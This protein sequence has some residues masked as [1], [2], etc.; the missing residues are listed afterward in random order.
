MND[1]TKTPEE[2]K[3]IQMVDVTTSLPKEVH[4]MADGLADIGVKAIEV[5]ADGWQAEDASP[6]IMKSVEKVPGMVDGI[7]MMD[8]E[9]EEVPYAFALA[10]AIAGRKVYAAI[11]ARKAAKIQG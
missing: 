10:W 7:D 3:P 9:A 2:K 11:K 8:D 1:E 5:T 4:E 6:I